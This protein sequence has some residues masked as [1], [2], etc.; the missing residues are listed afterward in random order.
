MDCSALL[1]FGLV[2]GHFCRILCNLTRNIFV[3]SLDEKNGKVFYGVEV[4]VRVD[5]K[6]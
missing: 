5:G 4:G 1:N 6:I 2:V 3:K